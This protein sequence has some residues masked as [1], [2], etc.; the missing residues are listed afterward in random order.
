MLV[1]Y[2][3]NLKLFF[4]VYWS[5]RLYYRIVNY[6]GSNKDLCIVLYRSYSFVYEFYGYKRYLNIGLEELIY[7]YLE[8]I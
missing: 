3:L 6:L 4:F 8:I 7:K 1:F 5:N 2:L